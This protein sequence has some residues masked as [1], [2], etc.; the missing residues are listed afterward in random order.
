MSVRSFNETN[1]L[2]TGYNQASNKEII[3]GWHQRNNTNRYYIIDDKQ[4]HKLGIYRN[5]QLVAE[6][7]A[8]HGK[9]NSTEGYTF[10]K[11]NSDGTYTDT[12]A[13]ADDMTI[14]YT[15][16]DGTINN[17]SGNL[18]T[19]A[20]M[21]YSNW[22]GIYNGVPGMIRQTKDM[23]DRG[24]SEAIPAG[25]HARNITPGANTNG[26]TGLSK[27]SLW[28]LQSI[29]GNTKNIE[30]Y[31][32]PVNEENKFFIENNQLWFKNSKNRPE[33]SQY[34]KQTIPSKIE[35]LTY[36]DADLD[37]EQKQMIEQFGQALID[38]KDTI[39]KALN[40][41]GYNITSKD[42][43]ELALQSLGIL[44]AESNYGE[45]KSGIGNLFGLIGKAL[46]MGGPDYWSK[47]YTFKQNKENDS[48]GPTQIR[49]KW[50]NEDMKKI[51]SK[52]F[53]NLNSESTVLFPEAAAIVT[54]LRLVQGEYSKKYKR[55]NNTG[56]T[57]WN[58]SD[59]YYNN[60]TNRMKNRQ[61]DWQLNYSFRQGGKVNKLQQFLKY[62]DGGA[63]QQKTSPFTKDNLRNTFSAWFTDD[64]VEKMNSMYN[65]MKNTLGWSDRNIAATF[66]NI[67]QETA[68]KYL[69]DWNVNPFGAF[70]FLGGRKKHFEKWAKDNGYELGSLSAASYLDYVIKNAIDDRMDDVIRARELAQ[71]G[72]KT[73]SINAAKTLSWAEDQIKKGT[74]YPVADLTAAWDDDSLDLG[75]ITK[76]FANT[77]ERAKDFEMNMNERV[78]HANKIY[79]LIKQ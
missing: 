4:T 65:H 62:R 29:L 47:Y 12:W 9:N 11:R 59:N 49:W 37:D 6:F 18:S 23:L 74:F 63:I 79:S 43:N 67:M 24:R 56:I 25:I 54:I 55:T 40:E 32:L 71:T 17:L 19:P 52:Y 3:N 30:T 2:E 45:R 21:F 34:Y 78:E 38:H 69:D 7:D 50:I 64:Q 10:K 53:P 27:E 41:Q 76:L 46:G 48:I 13:S 51:L 39:I 20:G 5:G 33:V 15:K 44:G 35:G 73:D 28:R 16:D 77:I 75:Y 60:V 26:C 72:N 58:S 22:S 66:G 42:Y 70:Q 57:S 8:I 61:F 36:N 1:Q 68:F 31:I 14:S